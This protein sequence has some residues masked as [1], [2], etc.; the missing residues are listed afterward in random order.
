MNFILEENN[1]L[2]LNP[3][4]RKLVIVG[5]ILIILIF[6]IVGLFIVGFGFLGLKQF[7]KH[8]NFMR[9][10]AADR[11]YDYITDKSE[12]KEQLNNLK[13]RIFTVGHS[14]RIVHLLKGS[15]QKLDT[16]IF[17]YYYTV[18]SG[19]NSHTYSF[20]VA[21]I[22]LEKTK[23]PHIFL[24]SDK[25][26]HHF[27]RDL[28]GQDKDVRISL[29]QPYEKHFNLYCT[30]DYEIEVLQIFTKDLLDYLIEHGNK[31]SIEFHENK[32]Y[33]YDDKILNKEKDLGELYEVLNKIIDKSGGLLSRLHDDF[34]SMRNSYERV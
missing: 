21:E 9:K 11:N 28:F 12:I 16:K 18:G 33:I 15:H 20:T 34:D 24:K 4:M 13:A 7:L 32:I 14:K 19:K 26:W 6:N 2:I 5:S 23:F 22:T 1:Q 3:K 17:N 29:E 31:F 27:G 8:A 30:Q 25:M 10:F